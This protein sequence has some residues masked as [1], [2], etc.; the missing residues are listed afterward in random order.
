MIIVPKEAPEN[1]EKALREAVEL[2]GAQLNEIADKYGVM[3]DVTAYKDEGDE[4]G[5]RVLIAVTDEKRIVSVFRYL[6][7]EY[8]NDIEDA[9]VIWRKI[10]NG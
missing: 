2:I 5:K 7:G 9:S 4:Y 8:A 3:V 1:M 6:T 10:R